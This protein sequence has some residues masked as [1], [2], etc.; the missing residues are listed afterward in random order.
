M[1]WEERLSGLGEAMDKKLD[2]LS[3]ALG[4]RWTRAL[5]SAR[6]LRSDF[7]QYRRETRQTCM[8]WIRS[9][10]EILEKKMMAE[11]AQLKDTLMAQLASQVKQECQPVV[12]NDYEER[13]HSFEQPMMSVE[14]IIIDVS[15][16]LHTVQEATTMQA[17]KLKA[18]EAQQLDFIRRLNDVEYQLSSLEQHCGNINENVGYLHEHLQ[19]GV[20]QQ[21]ATLVD[22]MALME[23]GDSSHDDLSLRVKDV[24]T[25]LATARIEDRP[26]GI[27]DAH[28]SSG[29]EA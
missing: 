10:Q 25:R 4:D 12:K 29:S 16:N 11:F 13:Q 3:N 18:L 17:E 1:S 21:L 24:E 9:N 27:D 26:S 22:R 6:T 2:G 23:A 7:E 20:G 19:K 14:R 5:T 8:E 28:R 15:T